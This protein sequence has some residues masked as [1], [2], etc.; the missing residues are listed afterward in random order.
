MQINCVLPNKRAGAAQTIEPIRL[1]HKCLGIPNVRGSVQCKFYKETNMSLKVRG[2][3]KNLG[4]LVS[5]C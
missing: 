3:R 1:I 2:K 5:L 4:L